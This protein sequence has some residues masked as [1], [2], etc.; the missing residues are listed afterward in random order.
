MKKLILLTSLFFLI[1]TGAMAQD[2]KT[3]QTTTVAQ[4]NQAQIKFDKT[5]D[6]LGNF[7]EA[8]P[9]QSCVF[10]FTNIG[11][12]P[13]I[14]NQAVASCG[15]TV[16]EYTKQPIQPNGKGEIKVTYNGKGKFPGHFKKT[17]TI[18]TNGIPEMTRLYIEGVMEEAK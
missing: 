18:R 17:I 14:I 11:K 1:L 7:S 15:C 3:V 13:L 6:H 8:N 12:A 10:T 16:P 5:T 9:V 4:A 2:N